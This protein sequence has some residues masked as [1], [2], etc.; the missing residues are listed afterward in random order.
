[1]ND[2]AVMIE[3]RGDI[4]DINAKLQ[5]LNRDFKST[6][7][8]TK[9]A[10]DS[11]SAGFT[12][13]AGKVAG[14]AAGFVSIRSAIEIFKEFEKTAFTMRSTF[15]AATDY[16]AQ[17]A[18]A[19]SEGTIYHT[20]EVSYAFTKTADSMQR[21]GITGEKYMGLV[22]RAMD[23]GAAK[24]LELR[25]SID[26]IESAMRGEAEA[27]EYLGVTLNDT[28][29]KNIAFNGALK[30]Q[31]EKLSD[32]EKTMYRYQELMEQTGK[33]TGKAAEA[34]KDMWGQARE[35][36]NELKDN[37][38]FW[39]DKTNTLLGQMASE[40][41][42]GFLKQL[43]E[44][45]RES[46]QFWGNVFSG[47]ERVMLGGTQIAGPTGAQV[48][49][50]PIVYP[51]DILPKSGGGSFTGGASKSTTFD[52]TKDMDAHLRAWKE[53][54]ADKEKEAKKTAEKI[55]KYELWRYD[56]ESEAMLDFYYTNKK[57]N[58]NIATD[59][60]N[61]YMQITRDFDSV[62]A[63]TL[64]GKFKNLGDAWNALWDSMV[65]RVIDGVAKMA[66]EAAVATSVDWVTALFAAKGVW[67]VEDPGNKGVPAIVHEG[68]MIVPKD[69]AEK[70]RGSAHGGGTSGAW[71][72]V[73]GFRNEADPAVAKA[74]GRGTVNKWGQVGAIGLSQAL[75]GNISWGDFAK[76]MFSPQ[77]VLGSAF[78][79]GV[80]KAITASLGL[81]PKASEYGFNL[82]VLGG[83]FL[84]L[85]GPI[86]V[87]TGLL[88]LVLGN[89]VADAFDMRQD[90]ELRDLMEKYNFPI[91]DMK[92]LL[93]GGGAIGTEGMGGGYGTIG[94]SPAD[95]FGGFGIGG[96]AGDPFGGWDSFGFSLNR[97]GGYGGKMA[98]RGSPGAYGP[99]SGSSVGPGSAHG[100]FE[101]GSAYVPYTGP[102]LVHRG[103]RI[104]SAADNKA[105]IEAIN[106][107]G[108]AS[109]VVHVHI[110][111]F[112]GGRSAVR[113]LARDIEVELRN[114]SE[115]RH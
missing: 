92:R 77:A 8:E 45:L 81:D 73:T 114:L 64:K 46:R 43:A 20:N 113:Q 9:R 83:S 18:R 107:G 57:V 69:V 5:G 112:Y 3:I 36:G 90:E 27:S 71:D 103:E 25:E 41:N 37:V 84:G 22:Q 106:H 82:G 13:L 17:K 10:T 91:S 87:L 76:G 28:Y 4:R 75:Q 29:M 7:S 21:Y 79:G 11:M 72:A 94:H 86:G 62:V 61:A 96:F 102:A 110:G 66:T 70:I 80:P 49:R 108:S 88:G 33:Y 16:M 111:N 14:F 23:V 40:E 31:W 101:L 74:F 51:E 109:P 54:Q 55:Y 53:Y 39:L 19:M 34:T 44:A 12:S 98:G 32:N 68:E 42:K 58:E 47:N 97:G 100:R 1:M 105:L 99:G 50:K 15:G 56:Q 85:T 26:R 115:L 67:K 78:L 93:A 38:Y 48:V 63:D 52:T 30:D 35:L 95:P 6:A 2:K 104:F 59:A 65:N 60:K 24:G 89:Y